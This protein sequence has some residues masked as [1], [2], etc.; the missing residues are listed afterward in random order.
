MLKSAKKMIAC[1]GK[2][3]QSFELSGTVPDAAV[4]AMLGPT[5]NMR[6]PT[7]VVGSTLLVGYN[8]DVFADVLG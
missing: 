7:V 5:G 3:V 1:K 2:K 6:S 8:D 4:Q